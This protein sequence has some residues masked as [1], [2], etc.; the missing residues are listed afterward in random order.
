MSSLGHY[1]FCDNL[2]R[3]MIA[4]IS[5][6]GIAIGSFAYRY[7]RGDTHIK[8]FYFNLIFLLISALCMVSADHIILFFTSWGTAN[9]FLT[10]LMAHK[11]FW[12][13]ARAS[14]Q[15]ARRNFGLGLC[16]LIGAS[17]LLFYSTGQVSIQL[18]IQ[19]S[20]APEFLYPSLFLLLITALT[21]S[22]IWPFHKWLL[23][24]LNSPTPVSA[25][26]HAGLINGGGFLLTRFAPL[27]LNSINFMRMLFLIGMITAFLGT[28]FMLVQNDIKRMLAS[29]TMGQ[30]GFMIAQCGL[31]LFS[32]AVA[33]LCWH[34][35]FKAY[36]F[37]A[38]GIAAQET[39]RNL[40]FPPSIYNFIFSLGAG[41]LGAGVFAYISNI[42]FFPL[43][44]S[45]IVV[46]FAGIAATQ[47]A[48]IMTSRGG[49]ISYIAA[50]FGASIGGAFYALSVQMIEIL[51]GHEL[52]QPSSLELLHIVPTALFSIA[53]VSLLF[54][55]KILIRDGNY[56]AWYIKAYAWLITRSQP[57]PKTITSHRNQYRYE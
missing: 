27:C 31:G 37:L 4:L 32:A 47:L 45:F 12:P 17:C 23:S 55:K 11:V 33:H 19:S 50:L 15:L 21:Q 43:Q 25:L 26:M 14:A 52:W 22:A 1:F 41:A 48:L 40:G 8:N 51:L 20:I 30:M 24:S 10:R 42:N 56:P 39:R 7:M 35:L 38:S 44:S 13:A 36:L 34:G 46:I 49:A 57:D 6:V 29:S 2:A 3:I 16:T 28:L 53:W 5:F 18:I 54:D 9:Y